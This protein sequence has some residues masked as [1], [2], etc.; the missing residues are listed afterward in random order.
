MVHQDI[1][2]PK[3]PWSPHGVSDVVLA[4]H[5]DGMAIAFLH[6]VISF[7]VLHDETLRPG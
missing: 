6:E 1:Q 2:P 5:V 4:S 7:A 3:R